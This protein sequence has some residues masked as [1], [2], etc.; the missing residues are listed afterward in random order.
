LSELTSP[1][2]GDIK[3]EKV[4]KPEQIMIQRYYRRFLQAEQAVKPKHNVWNVLD[5]FDRAEQWKD[6]PMPPWLPRPVTN[7]IRYIR[8][9][10]RANLASAIPKASYSPVD[11]EDKKVVNDLQFAYDHV[12]THSK[13]ERLVRRCIDR[14]TLQGTSIGYVYFDDS[15]VRGKYYKPNDKRN[16]M[17]EGKI[18]V[19]RFPN[20]QFFPDPDAY[21][22]EDCKFIETTE[23]LP[24]AQVKNMKVFKDYAG[25]NLDL[26]KGTQL[27]M[28]S[29]ANGEIYKRDNY[30]SSNSM[31]NQQGNELVTLH[32]HYERY[33]NDNGKWQLDISYYIRNSDFLLLR[34]EDVQPNIYPFAAY[35]DEEE[36]NDFWGTSGCM[37]ILE[38]QKV[39]NKLNQTA[40][41]IS[42]M[43]QNPQK[44]VQRDSGINA[45]ELARTGTLA[46]KVWQSNIPQ[47]I[48]YLQHPDIPNG[49][50]ETEDRI[51]S[52]IKDM[53]GMNEA[54]TGQSVGSLTTST[55]VDSLIERAT[56]RDKDKSTQIDAFIEDLSDIIVLFII[57]HWKEK[58]PISRPLPNGGTEYGQ[59]NP[60]DKLTADNLEWRVKSDVYARSPMTQA[61]RRQQADKLMQMQGQFQFNPPLILPEEW[62][63]F[64][65]FDFKEQIL[66]RM[67]G[68]RQKLEQQDQQNMMQQIMQF[69][70]MGEQL[71]AQGASDD[72]IQQQIAPAVQQLLQQTQSTGASQSSEPQGQGSAPSDS[73]QPQGTTS[74][75][76]AANMANGS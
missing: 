43:H 64:Q 60:V 33:L 50:F 7:Y 73:G 59:F 42:M 58:R 55:G 48:E 2:F 57:H 14:G 71:K 28:D 51:T 29:D 20:S 5:T 25:E 19:K 69:I 61:S 13:L 16:A 56:V 22:I 44:V 12:W 23:M 11:P 6:V 8:T 46:G 1:I 74:Q 17:Y 34:L 52:D 63:L 47:P 75:V 30:P 32:T 54:Y 15:V 67:Q 72:E 3:D 10:K 70:Q 49:L 66:Q 40:A 26:Y 62:I 45:Q 39:L 36:E 37:D 31:S 35:Y 68:D 27:E 18:C 65:D 38:N 4:Q 9:M 41:T 76:S 24:L 21:R 53:A